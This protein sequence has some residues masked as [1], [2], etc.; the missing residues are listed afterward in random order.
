M[1]G[2]AGT[3]REERD[4]TKVSIWAVGVRGSPREQG[5]G[6]KTPWGGSRLITGASEEGLG[7]G[8]RS[9]RLSW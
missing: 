7:L 8:V 5:L 4:G 2:V 3:V 9:L 1:C 6:K